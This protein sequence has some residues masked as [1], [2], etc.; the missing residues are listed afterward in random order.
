MRKKYENEQKVPLFG[1]YTDPFGERRGT[2]DTR[3]AQ[4]IASVEPSYRRPFEPGKV[5][6]S[7]LGHSSVFLRMQEQNILID[8]VFSMFTSPVPFAGPRR[9]PGR[10]PKPGDFPGIDLVLITHSHYDHL[11]RKT[12]RSMDAQVKHYVVPEGVGA[13]LKRFGI[14][15][16][17][18]TELG[19]YEDYTRDGLMVT[20]VPSQHDSGR[21]PFSMDATLWG[22]F[23]LR[24][25]DY[26]VYQSGDG[27][28]AGHFSKIHEKYGDI[29]LAIMECGQYNQKWHAIHMFPEES[30]QACLDLHAKLAVP[31]H[32]GA[33][34]LS[35]HAWDDPPRRFS[36]RAEELGQPCRIMKINEWLTI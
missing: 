7:W 8:P 20:L 1:K 35:D 5:S 17:K 24:N 14:A 23:L 3:P 28:Y 26:T 36:Q 13:I 21:S 15:A 9:F 6:F 25:K 32:W 19:W 33:Y 12:I 11:D 31:V 27:G 4:P 30:V 29:D 10:A 16:D 34:V 18:V 2:G 22:G